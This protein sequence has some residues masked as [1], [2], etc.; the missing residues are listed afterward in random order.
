MEANV[1]VEDNFELFSS[2]AEYNLGKEG[3]FN[4]QDGK[5]SSDFARATHLCY[6]L[7]IEPFL[8][9]S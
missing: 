2:L 1:Y 5:L 8:P 3:F 9:L 4:L 7:F 6:C